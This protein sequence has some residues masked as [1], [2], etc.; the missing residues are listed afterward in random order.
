KRIAGEKPRLADEI[1]TLRVTG[2]SPGGVCPYGLS[3]VKIIVDQSLQQYDTVFPA[4]GTSGSAVETNFEELVR[5]TGAE[6]ADVS[7]PMSQS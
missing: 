4:A 6:A 1:E 5:I 7:N 2:F 3:G